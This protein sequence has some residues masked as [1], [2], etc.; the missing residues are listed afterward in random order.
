[1][2]SGAERRLS[3]EVI[4]SLKIDKY[5]RMEQA[6]GMMASGEFSQAA[7]LL[8]GVYEVAEEKHIQLIVGA[9]W[10]NCLDLAGKPDACVGA[11]IE[12]L[13]MRPGDLADSVA[14]Q[15]LP[16][17]A[18]GRAKLAQVVADELSVSFDLRTK[19]LLGELLA[20]LE[21]APEKSTPE[22]SPPKDSTAVGASQASGGV[23]GGIGGGGP[24]STVDEVGVLIES[25]KVAEA[26]KLANKL[27][28]DRE[29]NLSQ[30]LYQRGVCE[31]KLGRPKDAALAYMRVVVHFNARTS[32]WYVASLIGA[33]EA[34]KELG[35]TDHARQLLEEAVTLTKG[36][37]AKQA[38]HAAATKLLGSI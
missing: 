5:P 8:G 17:D 29:G 1:M 15:V 22:S 3:L 7:D 25:G 31:A 32:R 11:F 35:Q 20:R 37:D 18:A 4:E 2:P 30:R 12:Y 19:K 14:P 36:D 9:K 38:E 10:V 34:L 16:Q 26:L 23:G 21:A 27:I 24:A 6:E 33:G 13:R 28:A